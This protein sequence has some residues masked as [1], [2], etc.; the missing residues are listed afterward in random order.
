MCA[1]TVEGRTLL[2]TAGDDG[3]VRVTDLA[4]DARTEVLGEGLNIDTLCPVRAGGRTLLAVAETREP[5]QH[6][7]RLWDPGAAR[8]SRRPPRQVS[9]GYR[10][11]AMREVTFGGR[12][13]LAL[14]TATSDPDPYA[15]EE[16]TVWL[17]D[18]D[19]VATAAAP[20]IHDRPVATLAAVPVG[21]RVMVASGSADHTVRMWDPATGQA[22]WFA[23]RHVTEV[24]A[25]CSVPVAEGHLVASTGDTTV[26]LS[27]PEDGEEVRVLKGHTSAVSAVCPVASDGRRLLASGGYD[28]TVRLWDTRT[29]RTVRTLEHPSG[30]YALATVELDG[31]AVLVS[32]GSE[33][34]LLLWDDPSSGSPPRRLAGHD[35]GWIQGLCV[36]RDG[37]SALVAT[38]GSD[39][40]VRLWDP[41]TGRPGRVLTGHTGEV[42]GVCPVRVDGVTL[43]A[44]AGMDAQVRLWDLS[45]G[46]TR[47][48]IHV[49]DPATSCVE[50]D[51]TL[52]V[53]L[54]TGLLAVRPSG[55]G[56]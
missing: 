49:R 37:G 23:H 6:V 30:V 52:V 39:G 42:R 1:L 38:G 16:G 10:I 22:L 54:A 44:S 5:Y 32:A 51:G 9:G 29:G 21:G 50:V 13:R 18:P 27:R 24:R 43:L 48:V 20:V 33:G 36:V 11:G 7:V 26:R 31:R 14:G 35:T 19:G 47:A 56:G 40:T 45:T 3:S 34:M 46:R 17:A 55:L 53:G 8:R 41:G 28:R 15:T 12:T 25:V 4:A 2:A